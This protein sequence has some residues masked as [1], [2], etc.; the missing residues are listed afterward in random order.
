MQNLI[1]TARNYLMPQ[2]VN[3]LSLLPLTDLIS[4]QE[5]SKSQTF[6]ASAQYYNARANALAA[7]YGG[8]QGSITGALGSGIETALGALTSKDSSTGQNQIMS[9]IGKFFGNSV[10]KG[11]GAGALGSAAVSA[12]GSAATGGDGLSS[13]SFMGG[14]DTSGIMSALG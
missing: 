13:G 14:L 3:P 6:N 11:A 1:G 10:N 4:G 7:Q 8:P 9:L 2:P 12:G 5:W